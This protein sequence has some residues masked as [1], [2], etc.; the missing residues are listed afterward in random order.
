MIAAGKAARELTPQM[1][2]TAQA[3][4]GSFTRDKT[5]EPLVERLRT[6]VRRHRGTTEE[7]R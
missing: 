4:A 3:H 6:A 5:L 7:N 1:R 2:A